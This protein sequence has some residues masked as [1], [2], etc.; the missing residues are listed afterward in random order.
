MM[1]IIQSILVIILTLYN[2]FEWKLKAAFQPKRKGLYNLMMT[3]ETKPISVLEKTRWA[4]RKDEATR[5]LLELISTSLWFHVVTCKTPNEIW[6]TLEG[7][8]GK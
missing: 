5:I 8:F 2:H 6:T 3:T 1:Q 4:N 7:L